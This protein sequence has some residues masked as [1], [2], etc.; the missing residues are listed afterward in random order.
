[1]LRILGVACLTLVIAAAILV[2]AGSL[3]EKRART[4]SGRAVREIFTDWNYET[5]RR[6]S[7][8]RIRESPRMN[9]E[10]PKGFQ[11]GKAGLGALRDVG[12]PVGGVAIR[13]GNTEDRGWLFGR[14]EYTARFE[15]A[16]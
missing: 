11:W 2:G 13:W 5:A 15:N 12:R 10:G 9:A 7:M 6:L 3:A 8:K 4:F 14:Y 1:M 16:E